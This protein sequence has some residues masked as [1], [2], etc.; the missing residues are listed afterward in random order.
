MGSHLTL[1][2][3]IAGPGRKQH[4]VRSSSMENAIFS[5]SY[6]TSPDHFVSLTGR[7]PG[8]AFPLRKGAARR[9]T[10]TR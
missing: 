3:P 9:F 2:D 10:I 8:Y 4:F 7:T 5:N 6:T 1:F